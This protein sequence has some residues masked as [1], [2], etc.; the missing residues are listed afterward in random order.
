M[1]ELRYIHPSAV[2]MGD[3]T[4]GE[5]VS[6]WPTAVIRGDMAPIHVGAWTNIQDGCVL[7]VDTGM[8]LKLGKNI[9]IGH[10][11]V[12]HSCTVG[13]NSMIGIG[14]I[15][16]DGAEIGESCMVAA[17]SLV[18]PGKKIP[19][20]SL[21]MGKPARIIRFLSEAEI[22]KLSLSPKTYWKLALKAMENE[23]E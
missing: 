19:P 5:Y 3:V 4:L 16:L 10:R 23:Q 11:A 1:E 12:L 21:V 22:E 14:A 15:V 9:T 2:I 13:D 8:P 20:N 18:S 6:V 7:H 17:G